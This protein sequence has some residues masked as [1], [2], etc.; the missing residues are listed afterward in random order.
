MEKVQRIAL[1]IGASSEGGLGE[2][3]A[4]RLHADGLRVLVAGR[5]RGP[6]EA[7]ATEVGGHALSCDVTD[8]NSI[9][10]MVAE[11]GAVDVL[12]NAAGT[13]VGQSI[14][15]TRREQ[16]DS[17]LAVHVTGNILLLKHV[18]PGMPRGGSIILFS[19]VT[20]KLAGHGLAAYG[21]AKAALDHVVRI[22]ALE[23][24]PLGIRVNA[25][26]PG[27]TRTPMTEG[28]LAD[29]KLQ[30][31]YRRE[32]A[33]GELTQ[34]AQVAA[35]VS[36]LAGGDCYSTGEILHVSGGAHLCRLPR[37]DELRR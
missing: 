25:V 10:A 27:F 26:A 23:F 7:L 24:G 32:T 37:V 34:P 5:R 4:R 33:M 28:F 1:V 17:Q 30:A 36:Y 3:A 2:A 21:A 22:A 35:A 11:A 14:L 9:A 29:E 16:I 19:S 20:S 15:K 8:E 18:A 31:L 12:V 6:L 13:T